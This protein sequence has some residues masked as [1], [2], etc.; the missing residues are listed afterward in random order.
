M[1][2]DSDA[3][4][5]EIIEPN[6]MLSRTDDL[7]DLLNDAKLTILQLQ[8]EI[9]SLKSEIAILRQQNREYSKHFEFTQNESRPKSAH[10][11][12]VVNT[13][14]TKTKAKLPAESPKDDS[15]PI[16]LEPIIIVKGSQGN[17]PVKLHAN[18]NAD[19]HGALE[20]HSNRDHDEHSLM[21][22][23]IQSSD[24]IYVL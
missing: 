16:P 3:S 17:S 22:D 23:Q 9:E 5:V 8:T 2:G 1:A 14:E 13:T 10:H 20:D 7:T 21:S 6:D 12:H 24:N 11:Q 15:V 18:A 4:P 19:H